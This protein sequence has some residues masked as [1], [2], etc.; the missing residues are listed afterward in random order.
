MKR[1][2]FEKDK[3][4]EDNI[5]KDLKKENNGSTLKGI[6]HLLDLK[7][8]TKQSRTKIIGYIRSLFESENK[9]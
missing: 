8:K 2:G 4:I 6:R 1:S 5:T 3:R 7:K 9:E